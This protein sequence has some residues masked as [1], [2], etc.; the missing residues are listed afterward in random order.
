[1]LRAGLDTDLPFPPPALAFRGVAP[2]LDSVRE[3][4]EPASRL[5]LTVSR[6]TGV[7]IHAAAA[8]SLCLTALILASCGSTQKPEPQIRTVEVLKIV[9]KPCVDSSFPSKP[10]TPSIEALKRLSPEER[11]KAI[12][13]AFIVLAPWAEKADQQLKS[14]QE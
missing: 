12:G 9:A 3:L 1:M 10:S 14:C 5:A 13:A 7:S 6:V 8:L 4:K 11:L 2:D